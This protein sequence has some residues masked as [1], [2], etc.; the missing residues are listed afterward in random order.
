MTRAEIEDLAIAQKLIDEGLRL[1]IV[2]H[3][4]NITTLAARSLWH[5]SHGRK[6]PNGK[7]PETSL[8][9][10]KT[11]TDAANIAAFAVFYIQ[12]YGVDY[13]VTAQKLYTAFILFKKLIP[14]FDINAAYRVIKD[15]YIGFAS[16]NRCDECEAAYIYIP[17]HKRGNKCP[18]CISGR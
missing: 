8:Y 17:E 5:E 16:L 6:P 15:L 11:S 13:R 12:T 4:T 2:Q 3:L 7:L 9:F 14:S 18:F 10:M 1:S